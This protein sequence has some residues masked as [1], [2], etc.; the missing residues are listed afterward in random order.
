[1]N[2]IPVTADNPKLRILGRTDRSRT[3]VALD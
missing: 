1:M 3:P 2:T